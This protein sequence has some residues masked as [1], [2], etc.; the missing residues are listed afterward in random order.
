MVGVEVKWGDELDY[1]PFPEIKNGLVILVDTLRATTTI[2]VALASGASKVIAVGCIE[3]SLELKKKLKGSVLAG[4]RSG[5]R[6]DGFDFGNSPLELQIELLKNRNATV[7]LNTGNCCRILENIVKYDAS[8]VAASLVNASAVAKYAV[9]KK[10]GLDAILIVPVGTYHMHGKELSPPLRS[11]EDSVVSALI[12]KKILEGNSGV[13]P[14]QSAKKFLAELEYAGSLEDP[15]SIV[16]Y[17]WGAEYSRYLLWMDAQNG[18]HANRLDMEVCFKPDSHSIVPV[19]KHGEGY[20][21][22]TVEG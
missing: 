9:K 20:Q 4:E 18:N 8:V 10:P 13:E 16:K 3:K 5:K 12:L 19:L 11:G 1:I 22:F 15:S 21:Y 14:A 17:L 6:V 2:P 7:I